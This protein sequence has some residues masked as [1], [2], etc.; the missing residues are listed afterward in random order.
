MAYSILIMGCDYK[1][2][3][4]IYVS[5]EENNFKTNNN[6]VKVLNF[7]RGMAWSERLRE[8]IRKIDSKAILLLLDDFIVESEIEL[9]ELDKIAALINE[10]DNIAC[11]TLNTVEMKNASSDVYF[12]R[13]YERHVFGRYKTTLQAGMWNKNELLDILNDKENAWEIE[14]F[15]NIR[16]YISH[17]K[18]YALIDK[19]LKPLNYNDGL[20][21][22]QGKL[23]RNE[24]ERLS[25]KFDYD[26]YVKG[27]KDNGGVIVR[28]NIKFYKRV[29]RRI[30]IIIYSIKY[31]AKYIVE[32]V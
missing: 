3:K 6:K 9:E 13:Y 18:Y 20:F 19:S 24:I 11:F 23:N 8:S 28:D 1:G 14:I 30:K 16:S 26:F 15:A 22:L 27:M 2:E 7:K 4:S 29:I 12:E 25:R 17:R 5:V 21:C 10:N 32:R 31:L